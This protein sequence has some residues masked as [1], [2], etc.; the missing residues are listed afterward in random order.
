MYSK[1]SKPDA[2]L[3]TLTLFG[4]GTLVTATLQMMLG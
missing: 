3:V 1:T 4:I 2:L